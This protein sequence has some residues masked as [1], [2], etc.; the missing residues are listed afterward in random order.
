MSPETEEGWYDPEATT[1]GDRLSGARE[2]AG[3]TQEQL[4]KRI[5]VKIKTMKAWE[6]NLSEPRAN[7]LSHLAG[8][9]NVTLRWLL[10]GEGTGP[11]NPVVGDLSPDVNVLL[12]ELRDVQNQLALSSER[13]G[14]LERQLRAT[15]KV[16]AVD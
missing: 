8:M 11:G 15:L 9:L 3:M 6:N 16:E 14:R 5:G 1:F 4:A 2:E 10:T 7:R 12:E 13:M